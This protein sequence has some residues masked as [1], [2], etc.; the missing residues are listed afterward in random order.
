MN[1]IHYPTFTP[2]MPTETKPGGEEPMQTGSWTVTS[3]R[4]KGRGAE[5]WHSVFS[6]ETLGTWSGT[7]LPEPPGEEKGA[8]ATTTERAVPNADFKPTELTTTSSK[9]PMGG[10]I[11]A[12]N[13][14]Q[15]CPPQGTLLK[16]Y[17]G[18]KK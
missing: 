17:C 3:C 1:P 11:Q 10:A 18:Y 4:K 7:A 5:I 8:S 13:R 15:Y 16:I 6:V 12:L 9:E 2:L 14:A